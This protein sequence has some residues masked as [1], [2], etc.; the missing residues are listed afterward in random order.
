MFVPM[1]IALIVQKLIFNEPL[2]EALGIS[3][4]LNGW[5]VVAWL[6]PPLVA[7]TKFGVSLLFPGVQYSQGIEGFFERFASTMK[8]EQIGQMKNQ[9]PQLPSIPYSLVFFK[10]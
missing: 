7:F 8:P 4:K 9:I 3:F 5:F 1:I 10:D 2:K 6:V